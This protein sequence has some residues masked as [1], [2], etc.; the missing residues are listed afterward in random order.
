MDLVYLREAN[1]AHLTK[2]TTETRTE[3]TSR[4][5]RGHVGQRRR[6]RP[7]KGGKLWKALDRTQKELAGHFYQLLLGH[8]AVAE[9]LR[10]VGQSPRDLCWWCGSGEHQTR[11]HLFVKYRRWGL[12][13]RRLWQKVRVTYEWGGAPTIRRLFGDESSAGDPG[14]LGGYQGGESARPDPLGQGSGYGRETG[15]F[16]D[17]GPG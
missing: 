12:G 15:G 16:L 5:V 10:R 4:W 17:E 9:Y 3:A 11:Y 7:S 1:L 14:I 13:I 6:Y 2:G 8:A